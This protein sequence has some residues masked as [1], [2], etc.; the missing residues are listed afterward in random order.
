MSEISVD[1][2]K[3]PK[4]KSLGVPFGIGG[5][6]VYEK[7]HDV[8]FG[9]SLRETGEG[10]T[11]KRANINSGNSETDNS[12][13][14]P[15]QTITLNYIGGFFDGEGSITVGIYKSP[16]TKYG[17]GFFTRIS[18]SQK[19]SEILKLIRDTIQLGK[20]E[21]FKSYSD[22]RIRDKDECLKFIQLMEKRVLIKRRQLFLLKK[23]IHILY[24]RIS[25]GKCPKT[26][27]TK[28]ETLRLLDIIGRLRQL[29]RKGPNSTNLK[30]ARKNVANFDERRYRQE[31]AKAKQI[32]LRNLWWN[33]PNAIN[34]RKKAKAEAGL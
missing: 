28:D 11:E 17:Y 20:L 30:Q 27:Y 31:I 8:S 10:E 6:G 32:Q 26:P 12:R 9:R 15:K 21:T 22:L 5:N 23:A 13:I 3:Y 33:K 25:K 4:L 18:I 2:F 19:T 1:I 16:K 14:L 34:P 7:V 29:N 24:K